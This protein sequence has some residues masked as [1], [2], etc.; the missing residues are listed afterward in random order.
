MAILH[1][2]RNSA[3]AAGIMK[4]KSDLSPVGNWARYL[5]PFF[6]S[7]FHGRLQDRVHPARGTLSHRKQPRG[8]LGGEWHGKLNGVDAERF[9]D[10]TERCRVRF[11]GIS[12]PQ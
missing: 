3:Y 6:G 5:L 1:E 4:R 7:Y 9:S 8:D 2:K 11:R 12:A 10:I